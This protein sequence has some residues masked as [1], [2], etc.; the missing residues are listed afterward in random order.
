M[1]NGETNRLGRFCRMSR[2][3]LPI[4]RRGTCLTL[5]NAEMFGTRTRRHLR[6]EPARQSSWA[7]AGKW[8]FILAWPLMFACWSDHVGKWVQRNGLP[9]RVTTA[10]PVVIIGIMSFGVVLWWLSSRRLLR[11]ADALGF[12]L[13]TRCHYPLTGLGDSCECPE[14][15]ES[16]SLPDAKVAWEERRR[17]SPAWPWER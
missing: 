6:I 7:I 8:V 1:V 9:P 14:C 3:R 4:L 10:A 11:R 5:R 15:G 12:R 17:K 13:C 2:N 16:Y